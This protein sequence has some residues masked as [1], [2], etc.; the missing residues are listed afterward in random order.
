MPKIR[1]TNLPEG[2]FRH[3]LLRANQR[4]ITASQFVQLA[5]WLNSDP[6]VPDGKWFRRFPDFT[7]CGEGELIKTFLL[8]GQLPIGE[9]LQ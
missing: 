5:G 9:Q 8:P 7:V 1:R 6:T 4:K 3:L 2:I